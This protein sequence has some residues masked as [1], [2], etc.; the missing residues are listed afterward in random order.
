MVRWRLRAAKALEDSKE[1][2]S[3][4][5][6]ENSAGGAGVSGLGLANFHARIYAGRMAK[7]AAKVKAARFEEWMTAM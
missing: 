7:H 2:E 3:A 5:G 6:D 1:E 4:Q